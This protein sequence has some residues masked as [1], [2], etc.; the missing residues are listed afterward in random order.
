MNPAHIHLLL[1][2]V[3]LFGALAVTILC[4]VALVRR[5]QGLARGGLVVALLTAIVALIVY[6]TGEPAEELIE[7]LPGV[8]EAIL[9]T[10]EEIALVATIVMGAY[11]ALAL[12]S[13]FAF[14]HGVTM[15][16]TRILLVVSLL[17]LAVL[18]YTAYLGGQIR[19]SE[20]RPE[21][22]D[23]DGALL[24]F[25]PPGPS[26]AL[27]TSGDGWVAA[28]DSADLIP[29]SIR[30]EHESL[31]AALEQAT[32]EDGEI[33]KAARAL[34]AIMEPHFVKEEGL[35]LPPLG[36][37]PALA[38]GKS[39]QDPARIVSL[40]ARLETEL[41]TMI[42]EHGKISAAVDELV[43]AANAKKRP[44]IAEFGERIRHHARSE[45]EVTYP[46]AVVVGRCL[47]SRVDR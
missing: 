1:N 29:P 13:L 41:P 20:I 19:H 45:E 8:S 36:I 7:N 12:V 43:I 38:A 10:H 14:R 21:T 9:E 33:G 27:A 3:P 28:R 40:A 18:A 23:A 46:A 42:E 2:H 16:F 11:G 4:L 39:I 15:R 17:P 26:I 47:Q 31:R 25:R 5:Q 37:L 6:L 32:R 44:E 22:A 35:A 34:A 30:E 24:R